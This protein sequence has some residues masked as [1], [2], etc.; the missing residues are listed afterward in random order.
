MLTAVFV[1]DILVSVVVNMVHHFNMNVGLG[2]TIAIYR[3][4]G[5]NLG[6]SC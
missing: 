4:E 3:Y 6:D 5:F 2:D 1:C